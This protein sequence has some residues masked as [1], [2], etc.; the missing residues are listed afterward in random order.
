MARYAKFAVAV[1]LICTLAGCGGSETPNGNKDAGKAATAPGDVYYFNNARIIPGD[2]NAVISDAVFLVENG[3]ITKIGTKEDVKPPQGAG[4]MDFEGQLLM[5]MLVN[6]S[7]HPGLNTGAVF[8]T[9]NYKKESVMNDLNRSLYYGIS[10]V[11]ISG[12]DKD[13]VTLQV[14]DDQRSG[15]AGGATVFSAGR[16][17]TGKGGSFLKDM[18]IQ[19]GSEADARGAVIENA[20]KKADFIAIWNDDSTGTARLS[21][22]I[23]NAVIDEAKK[24]NLKVVAFVFSLADAKEMVKA[25]V[26]GIIHSIRDRDVDDELVNDMKAKNVFYAPTLTA[27]ESLFIYADKPNWLG[28]QSMR[29]VYPAQLS[30]FLA[31][32]VFIGK[33]KR[34]P[35]LAKYKEQYG[36]ALKN[37]KKI[38]AGG[39]KVV[40]G[41]DSGIANTFPGYFE[42]REL[43]LMADAGMSPM[44]I[45]KSA[46]SVSADVI[47]LKDGGSIAVGKRADFL[48]MSSDPLEK[49]ANSKEIAMMYRGGVQV[50][51]LPLIQNIQMEVPKITAA[52]RAKEADAQKADAIAQAD[53]KLTHYGKFPLGPSAMVAGL[54]V[55]TP[56]YSTHRDKIGPPHQIT[57]SGKA[58]AAEFREFYTAA[59]SR[60]GWVAAGNCF[61]KKNVVTG[62]TNSL[63]IDASNGTAV[64]NIVEK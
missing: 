36:V 30:A 34:D 33:M 35:N 4:R 26:H 41:A 17:I 13:D 51:R 6:L 1:M 2:G 40:L 63:C 20:G 5:P 61:E 46:T 45:I 52:D 15:K 19:V 43:Q 31:D 27:H 47:G 28:E 7:G 12:S 55:P 54:A 49:I 3:I 21:P 23:T 32:S 10:A 22:A 29:E 39:V 57:V 8:S 18:L 24:K 16:G 53:A 62:K 56:K 48:V 44:D 64:I 38:A 25:G 60:G 37:L 11:L 50:E 14:R 59:L 42:H 9:E 58:T